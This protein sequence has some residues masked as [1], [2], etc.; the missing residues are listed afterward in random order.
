MKK[1]SYLTFLA[2]I[3]LLAST[4]KAVAW[5]QKEEEADETGDVTLKA[6]PQSKDAIFKRNENIL[7]KL[8]LQNKTGDMQTGNVSYLITTDEGQ[9]I[10]PGLCTYRYET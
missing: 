9:K 3:V 4:L 2:L 6:T 7:Y 10:T 8:Q 5:Q 1:I